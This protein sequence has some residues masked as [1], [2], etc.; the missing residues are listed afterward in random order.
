MK[1]AKWLLPA[2]ALVL[3]VI[4]VSNRSHARLLHEITIPE[5][6]E[7]E[8]FIWEVPVY[9]QT[10]PA[11]TTALVSELETEVSTFLTEG[12]RAPWMLTLG[13][14]GAIIY[15]AEPLETAY[16]L[17]LTYPYLSPD[18]QS[19]VRAF[20]TAEQF[21]Y[22][23]LWDRY[24]W[25]TGLTYISGTVT[26]SPTLRREA[27]PPGPYAYCGVTRT[28][29][30]DW[31][32]YA[33]FTARDAFDRLYD[34]WFYAY[35]TG[36]WSYIESHWNTIR[37]T[38]SVIY[39]VH[40]DEVLLGMPIDATLSQSDDSANRR[41]SA[42]IA[43]TRIA[44]HMGDNAEVM[45]GIDAATH[46]MQ[47]RLRYTNLNR[48]TPWEGSVSDTTQAN[49][50]NGDMIFDNSGGIFI[51]TRGAHQTNI[52]E[53]REMRPEVGRLL[54]TYALVEFQHYDNFINTTKPGVFMQFAPDYAQGE[55]PNFFPHNTQAIFLTKALV[56]HSPTAELEQWIDV[57]WVRQDYFYWERLA[58][59]IDGYGSLC[60]D[61][62]RTS[63]S[64][65]ALPRNRVAL[66]LVLQ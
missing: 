12:R 51:T 7:L 15:F 48:P 18:L 61:D 16:Y 31:Y 54:S 30:S 49:W 36:D 65:C 45:W 9:T 58:R 40:N 8:H 42:L 59:V 63:I 13:R 64:E 57:P 24:D 1:W 21:R 41:V 3:V 53:Y 14:A 44:Y 35:R 37:D 22:M 34:L 55:V 66:P 33:T 32:S 43:Y 29:E 39:D 56:M 26:F 4:L 25:S 46:A 17:A 28:C 6:S 19:Q 5:Q 60:L 11:L 38:K 2:L 27:I 52:P 23:P 47:T 10:N 20:V 50:E 62:V